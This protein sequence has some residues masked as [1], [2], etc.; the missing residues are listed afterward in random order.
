MRDLQPLALPDTLDPLV[1][2]CPARLAHNDVARLGDVL[3][4]LEADLGGPT[5]LKIERAFS[6]SYFNY[7]SDRDQVSSH[8][9]ELFLRD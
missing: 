2:D 9:R 8:T 3:V 6:F 7:S 1:V 4:E 5:Q